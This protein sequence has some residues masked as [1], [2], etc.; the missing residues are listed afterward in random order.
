MATTD[1]ASLS[2]AYAATIQALLSPTESALSSVYAAQ[3]FVSKP[4]PGSGSGPWQLVCR[5]A[6]LLVIDR[7]RKATVIRGYDVQAGIRLAVDAE[8][9][10]ELRYER[11][12]VRKQ[13]AC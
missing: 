11:D 1:V 10:Y 8:I 13:S 7:A 2:K 9:P 5:G 6:L 4:V 3:L 12:S